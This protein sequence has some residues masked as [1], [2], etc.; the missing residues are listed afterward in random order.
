MDWAALVLAETGFHGASG[1]ILAVW[2]WGVPDGVP[3]GVIPVS[4]QPLRSVQFDP[5][6]P[7]WILTSGDDGYAR[8]FNINTSTEVGYADAEDASLEDAAFSP[9]GKLIAVAG[10]EGDAQIYFVGKQ[11]RKPVAFKQFG[12]AF[13]KDGS[14]VTSVAF[15]P[16]GTRVMTT[17][18]GGY[19]E[20]FYATSPSHANIDQLEEPDYNS[21]TTGAFSPSGGFILTG[22]DDGTARIWNLDSDQPFVS[23]A[24]HEGPINALAINKAGRIL[25]TAS[26]DGTAR[27]WSTEPIDE[28]K[29]LLDQTDDVCSV[30]FS[31]TNLHLLA[32]GA[33]NG[34]VSLWNTS[35][36]SQLAR[37]STGSDYC[38]SAQ[39][40]HNGQFLVTTDGTQQARIW[41]VAH[42]AMPVATLDLDN[43]PACTNPAG[44]NNPGINHAIFSPNGK[45]VVTADEDG[46]ACVWMASRAATYRPIWKLISDSSGAPSAIEWAVFSPDSSK[47]LTSSDDGTAQIWDV[48]T[49]KLSQV[50]LEPTGAEISSAWFSP[51]DGGRLVVTS[52]DDGTSRVWN[53]TTGGQVEVL[54]EPNGDQVANA[55][56]SPNGQ[57]IVTCSGSIHVWSVATG[58][59]LTTFPYGDDLT[60]CEFSTNGSQI[61]AG[62]DGGQIRIFGTALAG[63]I[64]Q[65][66]QIAQQRVTR[67]LTPA[68]KQRYGI[69]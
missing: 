48:Q 29:L 38:A 3:L 56:F 45:Y 5:A 49:R 43:Y 22:G 41:A 18:T 31:P 63:S 46:S 12:A 14:K 54:A 30:A 37:W 42:L 28:R 59:L 65:L 23:L 53:A 67:G 13:N 50:L 69:S 9:N 17:D 60:D 36:G 10:N 44:S 35:T 40:S 1:S 6:N 55:N 20:W 21:L 39:F 32:A 68:E 47:V 2:L 27:I 57:F 15:D 52:S 61:A 62:G 11:E 24:G 16:S 51:D 4:R 58:Q 25:I 33:D 64:K 66:E 19:A 26:V 7:L 34:T 8:V